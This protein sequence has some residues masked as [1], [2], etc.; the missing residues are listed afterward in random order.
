M[1]KNVRTSVACLCQK[2]LSQ[3]SCPNEMSENWR[4]QAEVGVG[5]PVTFSLCK[6]R[7]IPTAFPTRESYK[8]EHASLGSLDFV[9]GDD[10]SKLVLTATYQG[11]R[12]VRPRQTEL[13]NVSAMRLAIGLDAEA[14]S[15]KVK[16]T[17]NVSQ[18][19]PCSRVKLLNL[20]LNLAQNYSLQNNS[21]FGSK[22]ISSAKALR[23]DTELRFLSPKMSGKQCIVTALLRPYYLEQVR[24][25]QPS[26]FATRPCSSSSSLPH[27]RLG[28]G[29]TRY[30]LITFGSNLRFWLV[31]EPNWFIY[32]LLRHNCWSDST[33]LFSYPL[34]TFRRF[35]CLYRATRPF[36]SFSDSGVPSLC[37]ILRL[38]VARSSNIHFRY[39]FYIT[40][41]RFPSLFLSKWEDRR[42]I[43]NWYWY[44]AKFAPLNTRLDN[45]ISQIGKI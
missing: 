8:T 44:P 30:G 1:K 25:E 17:S 21:L 40:S 41:L 45:V 19:S 38:S 18:F 31:G 14:T 9:V 22:Q 4:F 27:C 29:N 39:C 10:I 35:P 2:E 5:N 7:N 23:C 16:R 26:L 36:L 24:C 37:V 13:Q 11:D 34:Q 42:T 6:L 28:L 15:S 20:N 32:R 43:R 12:R 33:D 3:C